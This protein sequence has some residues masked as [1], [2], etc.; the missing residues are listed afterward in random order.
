[1]SPEMMSRLF[2]ALVLASGLLASGFMRHRAETAGGALKTTPEGGGLLV[3]L[4]V[5]ALVGI[6]PLIAYLI[7]PTFL[8]ATHIAPPTPLR[9]LGAVLAVGGILFALWAVHTLGSN[10]TATHYTRQGHA[11]ITTGPYRW[12]RHPLYT[13]GAISMLGIIAMTGVWVTGIALMVALTVLIARVPLEEAN[14]VEAFGD[15]Y[16]DYSARTGRFLPKVG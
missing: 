11:L 2:T 3:V 8:P 7:D 6:S 14:L 5:F 12:I 10:I 9:A 4:R 15:V 1:M 16:R 13:G